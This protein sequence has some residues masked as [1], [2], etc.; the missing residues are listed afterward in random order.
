MQVS[1][2]CN[3]VIDYWQSIKKWDMFF[4]S[5]VIFK[6]KSELYVVAANYFFY[7]TRSC[8]KRTLLDMLSKER[9]NYLSLRCL[10]SNKEHLSEE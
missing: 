6:P 3:Y 4:S 5:E 1:S 7:S 9:K 10:E 8:S 2:V